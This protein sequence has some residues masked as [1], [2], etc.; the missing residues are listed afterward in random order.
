M[1]KKQANAEKT[2]RWSKAKIWPMVCN[3]LVAMRKQ[4][5]ST[6][7]GGQDVRDNPTHL[8]CA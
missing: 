8:S 1:T 6:T 5:S 3:A 4:T 2:V 7:P